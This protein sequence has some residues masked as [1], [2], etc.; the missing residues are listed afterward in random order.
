MSIVYY[1]KYKFANSINIQAYTILT[2]DFKEL[3]KCDIP[4][5]N[6]RFPRY[7]LSYE[8]THNKV[9]PLYDVYVAI[10]QGKKYIAWFSF[11][12]DKD[13]CYLIELNRE[14]RIV[15]I[16]YNPC[17]H[18]QSGTLVYGSYD[19][20]FM[21]EDILLYKDISLHNI[22][23]DRKIGFLYDFFVQNPDPMFKLSAMWLIPPPPDVIASLPYAM[24]HLQHRSLHHI[25]PYL[26]IKID[27]PDVIRVNS[28]EYIKPKYIDISKK[29]Y[30]CPTVFQ[31]TA[32]LQTDIYHL[33]TYGKQKTLIYYNVACIPDYKTS[34]HMNGI[35]RNIKENKNLDYIEES[36]DD[37]DFQ[38]V[39]YDKY[40][41][42]QKTVNM[43]CVFNYKFKKWI[44]LTISTA[45]IVHI[46]NL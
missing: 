16:T 4:S 15:K 36:D 17:D 14:K 21:I 11:Y 29:Q 45:K 37:D 25:T 10:P 46:C 23:F 6:A 43:E 8:I 31:I 30:K 24:H 32:D 7:E 33:F 9:S 27:V 2:M 44:P 19:S 39:N 41:N 26:N 34:V 20:T 18:A 1:A 42:L 3:P 35:F 40:V 12:K 13:V 38:N 28:Q 22:T 5:F